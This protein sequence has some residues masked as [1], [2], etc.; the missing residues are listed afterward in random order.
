MKNTE[1]N[2][3]LKKLNINPKEPILLITA[4]EA[5]SNLME[6]IE[7]YCPSLKID[8]ISKDDL[9]KL[10]NTYADCIINYHPEDDHQQRAALLE[11]FEMLEQYGLSEDDYDSLDFY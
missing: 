9:L 1:P 7:E 2:K 10:L 6:V 11:N 5:L 8:K 3:L 4:E